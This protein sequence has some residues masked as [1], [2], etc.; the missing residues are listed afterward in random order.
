M[1]NF[2]AHAI[3]QKANKRNLA[4]SDLGGSFHRS[5]ASHFSDAPAELNH[6]VPRKRVVGI[7][8]DSFT[9]KA[10]ENYQIYYIVKV[11]SF[12]RNL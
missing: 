12:A 3:Q 10:L 1:S 2:S 7:G 8:S 11:N 9:N 5:L 4:T 6:K